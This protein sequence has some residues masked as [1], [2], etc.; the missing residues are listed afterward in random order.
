M[1]FT[2]EKG[3]IWMLQCPWPEQ[4]VGR[5]DSLVMV[6]FISRGHHHY[7]SPRLPAWDTTIILFAAQVER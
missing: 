4:A 5:G 7:G 1:R 2:S 6:L 3:E